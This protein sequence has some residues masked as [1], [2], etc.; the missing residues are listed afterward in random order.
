VVR[1][2]TAR[3]SA[4]ARRGGSAAGVPGRVLPSA[5]RPV[6]RRQ[7][8]RPALQARGTAARAGD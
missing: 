3:T 6:F 7:F 5:D 1:R 8:A 2:R 4:A